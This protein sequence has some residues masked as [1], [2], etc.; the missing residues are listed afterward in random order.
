MPS[1]SRAI[2]LDR[3]G[4]VRSAS[5]SRLSRSMSA[6]SVT[7]SPRIFAAVPGAGGSAGALL[8]SGAS[9]GT[10]HIAYTSRPNGISQAIER[11]NDMM[12]HQPAFRALHRSTCRRVEL[13]R[14][15]ER[16]VGCS[17]CRACSPPARRCPVSPPNVRSTSTHA[18]R[19][20][21]ESRLGWTVDRVE[22]AEAPTRPSPA[23][24]G[25]PRAPQGPARWVRGADGGRGRR[26]RAAVQGRGQAS[27][28][29]TT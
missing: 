5:T 10:L 4:I 14:S 12:N 17:R 7:F 25:S 21:G 1:S 3:L 28:T 27:T 20:N 29:S 22:I 15:R 8:R 6:A 18:R 13:P 24:A 9:H 23:P 11:L 19:C 2:L 16:T 26:R